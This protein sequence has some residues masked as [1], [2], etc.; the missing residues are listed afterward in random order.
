[1]RKNRPYLPMLLLP[2]LLPVSLAGCENNLIFMERSGFNLSIGVNDNPITPVQVNA[3][4]MRSIV[5]VVPGRGKAE[6]GQPSGEAVSLI[7]GYDLR[8]QEQ[9]SG[10]FNDKLTIRSQFASGAAAK[11]I[12]TAP[13]I[14]KKIANPKE[15]LPVGPAVKTRGSNAAA[16]VGKLPDDEVIALAKL[17]N[18]EGK[19]RLKFSTD[20]PAAARAGISSYAAGINSADEVEP[21][22]NGL[23]RL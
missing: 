5:A 6:S 22:E 17:L 20:N 2:L 12:A 15:T 3:G 9:D 13:E 8:Y 16:K 7:S 14:A 23:G 1:M 11:T 18:A 21:I 4:M 10:F 19:V